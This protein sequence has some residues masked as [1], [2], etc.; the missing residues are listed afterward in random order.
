MEKE[1]G[2]SISRGAGLPALVAPEL[3]A[4]FPELEAVTRFVGLRALVR[5]AGESLREDAFAFADANVFGVFDIPLTHGDSLAALSHANS[6][7]LS[8]SAA[9]RHFGDGEAMGE[10]VELEVYGEWGDF[11]VTGVY[12]DMPSTSHLH[13][14]GLVSFHNVYD[15]ALEW[16][17]PYTYM[18][19]LLP[20]SM[21]PAA[22]E[23]QLGAF[24]QERIPRRFTVFLQPLIE[25]HLH[26]NL[27]GEPNPVGSVRRLYLFSGIGVLILLAAC[28][29][30]VNLSTAVAGQRARE[31]GLRKVVGARRQQVVMQLLGEAFLTTGAALLLAVGL[32]ELALP[33]CQALF[34]V[35]LQLMT[36]PV[37]ELAAVLAALLLSVGGLSGVYAAVKLS[38]CQPVQVMKGIDHAGSEGRHM[39]RGLVLFQFIVSAGLVMVTSVMYAQ[40]RYLRSTDLGFAREQVVVIR[41]DRSLGDRTGAFM[42]RLRSHSQIEA[43]CGA[44][45]VPGRPDG[46]TFIASVGGQAVKTLRYEADY[47]LL[48]T[49]GLELVSGRAFSPEHGADVEG[50]MIVTEKFKATF[51]N[52]ATPHEATGWEREIIGVV[53]DFHARSLY[54]PIQPVVFGLEPDARS[55]VL[56]RAR[57]ERISETLA[58]IEATWQE[59][60]PEEPITYSFLDEDWER[61]YLSDRRLGQLI[62]LFAGLAVLIACLGLYG[63]IAFGVGRRTREIGIRKA[64]GASVA[65]IVGVLTREISALVGV[66]SIA[67]CP[68]AYWAARWWLEGFAYRIDLGPAYFVGGGGMALV[69]A[70]MTVGWTS[71]RAALANPVDVLRHE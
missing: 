31:V 62:G 66:A 22:V 68:V 44:R 49:L 43:A 33:G 3:E 34:G 5:H 24:S 1:S 18:Y 40:F 46:V 52:A 53:R 71:V 21:A 9:R 16:W 38:S 2:G 59:F 28:A 51:D 7:V 29:N 42:E 64:L 41:G 12:E 20:A 47:D 13:Y 65:H 37:G 35:P 30:F 19:V 58:Y 27:E 50:A 23:E 11:L 61:L 15:T 39:R 8:Q 10:T 26:S 17:A 36:M 4:Y 69:I 54:E 48:E 60:V 70:W 6:I 14:D 25:L 45:N 57:P 56:V 32:V 55:Y 67:A 63:L